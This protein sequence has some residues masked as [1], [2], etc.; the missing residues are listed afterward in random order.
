MPPAHLRGAPHLTEAIV[1]VR[2][3]VV[4]TKR[5]KF[6]HL[7]ILYD[8]PSDRGKAAAGSEAAEAEGVHRLG[9]GDA[10]DLTNCR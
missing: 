10:N 3:R 1:R 8:K 5:A 2:N 7:A 4:T 6:G 9:F